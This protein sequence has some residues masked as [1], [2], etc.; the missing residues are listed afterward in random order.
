[1]KN[2]SKISKLGK[3][4]LHGGHMGLLCLALGVSIPGLVS[5]QTGTCPA[6][7]TVAFGDSTG[8][9]ELGET[10][11]ITLTLEMGYV[12]E[13][14]TVDI[15]HFQYLLDCAE[16]EDYPS[17]TSQGNTV[18]F[19]HSSVATTC[20][21]ADGDV[22][23]DLQ[24][25]ADGDVTIDFTVL[26]SDP[27]A[28]RLDSSGSFG[29]FETCEVT[30]D[31][32]VD[33]LSEQNA[34]RD[35]FEITGWAGTDATCANGSTSSGTAGEI[36]LPISNPNTVFWV[37]KDFTDDNP[38]EVDIHFYC[39]AG[40]VMNP[41]FSI[42]DP[43]TDGIFDIK[44]FIVYGIPSIGADCTIWEDPIPAG[45]APSYI[46]GALP[47]AVYTELG[48]LEDDEGCYY[49]DVLS[50]EFTCDITNTGEPAEFIVNKEWVVANSGG[51]AIDGVATVTISCDS[52]ILP[53]VPVP[54]PESGIQ[55]GWLV[56]DYT[57]RGELRDGE[58]L[59]ALVD[60]SDG[61][62]LCEATETL[63]DSGVDAVDDCGKRKL[64]PG[65][66][67]EC[68]FV[69]T[70]YFEGVPTLN[71]YGIALMAMLMLGLGVFGFRRMG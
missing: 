26:N 51:K 1:M 48:A 7:I 24:T 4:A 25:T 27:A 28:I 50:G 37:T 30:F 59:V 18:T 36:S 35:V 71:Q 66:S 8:P 61:D 32:S 5:A 45:Y 39:N 15:S 58:S 63:T 46:A 23:A 41:D 10:I 33:A 16:S 21:S 6:G 12:A 14:T 52:M 17:C 44:G 20:E 53:G 2:S 49:T 56:D 38:D 40:T 65:Q 22:Y 9:F 64:L 47:G 11:P 3:K 29:T 60:T 67:S 55:P 69:N 42:T 70:V 57:K 31:V 43:A 13:A 62:A 19:D 34:T 68:T 54:E